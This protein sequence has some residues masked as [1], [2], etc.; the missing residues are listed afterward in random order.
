M[1]TTKFIKAIVTVA[2]ALTLGGCNKVGTYDVC[3]YGGTSA[4]VVA[5][6]SAAQRGAQT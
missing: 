1:K 6:Y 5:A 3:I 2:A 4:G